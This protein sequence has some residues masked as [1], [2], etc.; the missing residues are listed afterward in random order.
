MLHPLQVKK[1]THLF[2]IIDFDHNGYI[3]KEDFIGIV[4][5]IEIFTGVIGDHGIDLHQDASLI[6]RSISS[7]LSI[8]D[9]TYIDLNQWLDFIEHYMYGEN[10]QHI[11][12]NIHRLVGRIRDIFDKDG[13][14]RI[15]KLEF[16]SIFVSCR[17]EV[18]FASACFEQIDLNSDGFISI[19]ELLKATQDF[20]KSEEQHACGNQLFGV[21]GSSLFKTRKTI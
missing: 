11:D 21:M 7:Y 19:N 15:S 9:L 20:F 4:D 1:L 13:D 2:S 12:Q 5:N 14:S 18:R 8:D 17:V 16:M 10:Q 3:Q 6:W